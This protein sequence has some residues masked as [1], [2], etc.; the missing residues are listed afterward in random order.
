MGSASASGKTPH[1]CRKCRKKKFWDLAD[2]NYE[3][4]CPSCWDKTIKCRSCGEP[5]DSETVGKVLAA[6]SQRRAQ[7]GL[8]R[9]PIRYCKTCNKKMA[10]GGDTE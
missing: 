9:K 4:V 1:E 5:I 10:I 6:L 8:G 2:T 3:R 7:K